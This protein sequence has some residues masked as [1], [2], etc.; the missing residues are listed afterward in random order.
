M[1]AFSDLV[2]L[3]RLN[4]AIYHN[5]VVCGDWHIHEREPGITCFHIVTIGDCRMTVPGVIETKLSVG[6]LVIF[7][8]EIAHSMEPIVALQGP[9]EHLAYADATNRDGT[10]MLCGEVRF[11]HQASNQI[12]TALPSV[13]IIPND[14]NCHWLKPIVNLMIEESIKNEAAADVMIDRLAELLFMY[15]L[16][17][18]VSKNPGRS[19]VLALYGH[20]KL[21][22]AVNAMHRQPSS[23]WTLE[24]LAKCAAQSRTKFAKTFRELSGWTPMEYLTW[25]RMQLAW[26]YLTQ[27]DH[28]TVVADKVGYKSESSFLRA[29]KRTFDIN[30]GQVRRARA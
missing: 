5:A 6:D 27:G 1:E 17:H 11:Q 29:F 13:L 18:Y 2:R 22:H 12:L 19:G 24:E 21:A 25:W 20:A 7:P 8:K 10:G 14:E 16:R 23:P 26:T 4:V 30:A 28:V 9:Q 15:A 3:V